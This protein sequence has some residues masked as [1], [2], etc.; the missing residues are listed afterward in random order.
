[1]R[2]MGQLAVRT[3]SAGGRKT[4]ME[5]APRQS[6]HHTSS[7]QVQVS[8]AAAAAAVAAPA[9]GAAAA[10]ASDRSRRSLRV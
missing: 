9:V 1:M 4:P 6:L 5:T 3:I 8:A 10:A 2:G 7:T